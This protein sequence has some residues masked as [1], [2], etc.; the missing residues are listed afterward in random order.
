MVFLLLYSV[1]LVI[2]KEAKREK[3]INPQNRKLESPQAQLRK[4]HLLQV[5]EEQRQC[6]QFSE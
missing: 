4:K 1:H 3:K 6:S 2:L 5:D